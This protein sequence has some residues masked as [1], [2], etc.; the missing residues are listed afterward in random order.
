LVIAQAKRVSSRSCKESEQ[1]GR[2]EE[3]KEQKQLEITPGS[4]CSRD[5]D[6]C[7]SILASIGDTRS[8]S[9]RRQQ[10]EAATQVRCIFE[11]PRSFLRSCRAGSR[12]AH[13]PRGSAAG[14][15]SPQAEATHDDK[16]QEKVPSPF[17]P[18]FPPFL[19]PSSLNPRAFAILASRVSPPEAL[20][21]SYSTSH[22]ITLPLC[23]SFSLHAARGKLTSGHLL[24][25]EP[26]RAVS[27]A[28]SL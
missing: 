23:H 12:P 5:K 15:T 24:P 19:P 26:L 20:L 2:V 1:K 8:L 10:V 6:D 25:V 21:L 27:L 13:D 3:T 9:C 14:H 16:S 17:F 7:R 28:R 22:C 11:I 4:R 18:P